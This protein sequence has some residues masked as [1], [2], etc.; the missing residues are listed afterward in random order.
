MQMVGEE[1]AGPDSDLG[2]FR[3]G[4]AIWTVGIKSDSPDVELGDNQHGELLSVRNCDRT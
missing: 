2:S 3:L 4:K 1:V